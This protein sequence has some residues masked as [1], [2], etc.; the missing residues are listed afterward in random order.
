MQVELLLCRVGYSELVGEIIRLEGD[1]AT[2]QVCPDNLFGSKRPLYISLFCRK[3]DRYARSLSTYRSPYFVF[4]YF[5][6]T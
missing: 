6:F 1:F 3:F 4:F 2:I 5:L